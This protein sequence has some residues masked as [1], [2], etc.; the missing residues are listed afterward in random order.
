MIKLTNAYTGSEMWVHETRLEE[1][2][3]MG[4]KLAPLPDVQEIKKAK[5]ETAAKRKAAKA[6]D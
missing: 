5:A 2:L 6:K 1:Y 4:H 3:K